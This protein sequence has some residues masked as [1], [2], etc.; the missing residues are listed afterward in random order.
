M[1]AEYDPANALVDGLGEPVYIDTL[2]P[3]NVIE[4]IRKEAGAEAIAAAMI[5]ATSD[6]SE[7][8]ATS[9]AEAILPITNFCTFPEIM[10][11]GPESSHTPLYQRPTGAEFA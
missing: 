6:T 8:K 3:D 2:L 9:C 10:H 7:A 11:L 1:L 4:M 5:E